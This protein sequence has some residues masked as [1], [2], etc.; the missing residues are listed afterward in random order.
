MK[1]HRSDVKAVLQFAAWI[2]LICACGTEA[3]PATFA[4]G[5]AG[6]SFLTGTL[7]NPPRAGDGRLYIEDIN[8]LPA[9]TLVRLSGSRLKSNIDSAYAAAGRPSLKNGVYGSFDYSGMAWDNSGKRGWAFGGGHATSGSNGIHKL[10]VTRGKWVPEVYESYPG[11]NGYT[12][13]D[14]DFL[15][16][17][18]NENYTKGLFVVKSGDLSGLHDSGAIVV[19]TF[20]EQSPQLYVRPFAR[21][22]TGFA[23]KIQGNPWGTA[24]V[25]APGPEGFVTTQ[26]A[27]DAIFPNPANARAQIKTTWGNLWDGPM[28]SWHTYFFQTYLPDK[29]MLAYSAYGAPN[30]FVRLNGTGW[31]SLTDPDYA[32]F[33]TYLS[34]NSWGGLS[35]SRMIYDSTQ[36]K[37][38]FGSHVGNSANYWYTDPARL[39][40]L[41]ADGQY[42]FW[43]NHLLSYD[44]D[45]KA[46]GSKTLKANTNHTY[47]TAGTRFGDMGYYN[48]QGHIFNMAN[49][50]DTLA[51][52]GDSAS[53]IYAHHESEEGFGAVY[54]S[55]QGKLWAFAGGRNPRVT[56]YDIDSPQPGAGRNNSWLIPRRNISTSVTNLA[57]LA[58]NTT[59]GV[60]NRIQYFADA[61]LMVVCVNTEWEIYYCRVNTS[62]TI[63]ETPALGSR[64]SAI[65]LACSPNP[66]STGSHV[67]VTLSAASDVRLDLY[68]A[69]G[70]RVCTLKSGALQAG[71]HHF[72][73]NLLDADNRP[74]AVGIYL[75]KLTAGNRVLIQRTV[76]AK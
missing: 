31:A 73:W 45:T 11:Y 66:V 23:V 49:E 33:N 36:H 16:K 74:A 13:N 17:S 35:A 18:T 59:V 42:W 20:T 19:N 63:T 50:M 71:V 39:T 24:W 32:P 62:G 57:E 40:Q 46:W 68:N 67:S 51:D 38:W 4:T 25:E 29:N 54:L 52:F 44:L 76:V 14:N 60:Y 75:F 10:D 26:S 55:D 47:W 15:M 58:S 3:Q 41:G 43:S 72:S 21:S 53:G 30:Y 70:Q 69:A 48:G 37:I 8:A 28:C 7:W 65:Q 12:Q 27:Y 1:F 6:G 9:N 34:I 2:L 22:S 56:E 61:K 5:G 64:N